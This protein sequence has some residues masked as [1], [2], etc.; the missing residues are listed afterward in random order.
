VSASHLL[1]TVTVAVL[2]VEYELWLKKQLSI[3][4]SKQ[5]NTDIQYHIALRLVII[6]HYSKFYYVFESEKKTVKGSHV[7]LCIFNSCM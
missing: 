2:S 1:P 3:D 5:L 7:L 6:G 4:R